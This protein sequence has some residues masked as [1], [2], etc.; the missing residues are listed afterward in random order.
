MIAGMR[1]VQPPRAV[2]RSPRSRVMD[3]TQIGR[4]ANLPIGM[5]SRK[6]RAALDTCSA[7]DFVAPDGVLFRHTQSIVSAT[8]V[9]RNMPAVRNQNNKEDATGKS[10]ARSQADP[11]SARPDSRRPD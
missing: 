5:R 2:L 1:T 7:A 6:Y 4:K 8:T 10:V 3:I 9:P 11:Q